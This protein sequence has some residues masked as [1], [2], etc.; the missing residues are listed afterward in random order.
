MRNLTLTAKENYEKESDRF[1]NHEF[2]EIEE[3]RRDSINFRYSYSDSHE[4]RSGSIIS[5]LSNY[6]ISDF[7]EKEKKCTFS[8]LLLTHSRRY[9]K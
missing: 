4:P 1:Y 8:F 9:Y 3:S 6:T 7:N 5:N 2:A